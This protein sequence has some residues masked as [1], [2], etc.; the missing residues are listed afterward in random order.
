LSFRVELLSETVKSVNESLV[1]GDITN[2]LDLEGFNVNLL[3]IY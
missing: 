2:I 3:A 1:L